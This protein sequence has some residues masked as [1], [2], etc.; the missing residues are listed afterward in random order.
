MEKKFGLLSTTFNYLKSRFTTVDALL[1]LECK[2][3]MD[4]IFST[5]TFS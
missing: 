4:N 1:T 2:D 5:F 3:H